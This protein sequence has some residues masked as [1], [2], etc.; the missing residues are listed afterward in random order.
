MEST[1]LPQIMNML[2]YLP[3]H[4]KIRYATILVIGRYSDWTK[5]HPTFIP[6]QLNFISK[7]FEEK[8]AETRAAAA[9][10]LNY[11]CKSCNE[12][13]KFILLPHLVVKS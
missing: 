1:F 10:S 4:P 9:M 5:N 8:V 11:L 6:Y 2:P 7:G 13:R 12:V 3:E